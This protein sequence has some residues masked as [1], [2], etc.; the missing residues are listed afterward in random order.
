MIRVAKNLLSHIL[1]SNIFDRSIMVLASGTIGAQGI[2]VLAAP[3]LT[4]IY[5]PEAF[6]V[7]AI[8]TMLLTLIVSISS[9]SYQLAIP[10]SQDEEEVP[11]LAALSLV[12]VCVSAL[13]TG[14]LVLAYKRDIAELLNISNFERLSF[15]STD[16]RFIGRMFSG[17]SLLEYSR[18][19]IYRNC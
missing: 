5:S 18:K 2:L 13:L 8:Y 11:N 6:G 7:L 3:F 16:R 14:L 4:R 10:I 17:I 19:T 15:P 9:L 12:L 1:P